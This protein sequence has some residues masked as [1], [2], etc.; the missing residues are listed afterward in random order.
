MATVISDLYDA[1]I[2]AGA[3]DERARK[4]SEAMVAAENR[5][6]AFEMTLAKIEGEVI[7]V[8][9][10]VGVLVAGV[11]SLIMKAFFIS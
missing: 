10:M 8:K 9:W 2:S 3:S 7:L 11:A 4:A 6:W 1:L 5:F